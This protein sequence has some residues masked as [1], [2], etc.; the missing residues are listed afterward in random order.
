MRDSTPPERKPLSTHFNFQDLTNQQFERWTILYYAGRGD[1]G[2]EWYCECECGSKRIVEGFRLRK[3]LSR[4]CGCGDGSERHGLS[5]IP[6]Y[7]LWKA[8][9]RR[10]DNPNDQQYHS[11]GGRGIKVCQRWQDSFSCFLEDMGMRP[12]PAHQLDRIDN[13]GPYSPEN[14]KWSTRHEQCR[15]RRTNVLLTHNGQTKPLLDWAMEYGIRRETLTY[16][17]KKGWSTKRALET[18][19]M[20]R[21]SG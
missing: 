16:R 8:M 11:Y 15:N 17:V 5:K 9:K 4:S 20:G 10:T 2:S 1:H 12:S 7:Y 14:C 13:D 21:E 18:P 19:V 3:G 6:E